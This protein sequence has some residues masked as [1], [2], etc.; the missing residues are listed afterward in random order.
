MQ[1]LRVRPYAIVGSQAAVYACDSSKCLHGF[2]CGYPP[3]LFVVGDLYVSF[4][5]QIEFADL[6]CRISS[7]DDLFLGMDG[8]LLV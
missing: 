7:I 8:G 1:F 4:Q 6:I 2:V 3:T 5:T